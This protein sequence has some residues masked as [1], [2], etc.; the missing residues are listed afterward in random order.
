M[1]GALSPAPTL[2][3]PAWLSPAEQLRLNARWAVETHRVNART[4]YRDRRGEAM[5]LWWL[6]TQRDIAARCFRAAR[7][8]EAGA[9]VGATLDRHGIRGAVTV[10]W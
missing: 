10:W 9:D 6:A 3:V 4:P 5:R 7:D 8:V 2:S 1:D